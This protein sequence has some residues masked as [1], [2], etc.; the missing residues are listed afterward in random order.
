VSTLVG[1][2][3]FPPG[4]GFHYSSTNYLLLR[5]IAE[6]V[7]GE[8]VSAEI[9]RRFLAPLGLDHTV[10]LD[11]NPFVPGEYQV[12]HDWWDADGDG[13][14]DDVSSRPS[15]WIATRSPCVIYAT[16]A[17]L[18]RWSQALYGGEVLGPESRAEM[19]AFHRP[20]PTSPGEPLAT[21]YGLGTQELRLGGLEVWGHL[22]WQY[23]YTSAMLYLPKRSASIV[24]LL[25]DNN[26]MLSNLAFFSLWLVLACGQAVARCFAVAFS[27]LSLLST[28][29]LWPAN[30]LIRLIR[31]RKAGAPKRGRAEVVV[32]WVART[33]VVLAA[34]TLVAILCL[35]ILH[36][37]SPQ[38]PLVWRGGTPVVR[39]LLGL[40]AASVL[41]AVVLVIAGSLVWIRGYWTMGW[42][43]HYTLIVLGVLIGVYFSLQPV[44]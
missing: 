6:Q 9:R 23:G 7:T 40:S 36:S 41:L 32:T 44:L 34:V 11:S 24:V 4:E 27:A 16:A 2:P 8:P 13:V 42:R 25:N 39:L 22:G 31:K 20:A 21:G 30:G 3:Y 1:E 10:V 17:D 37:W 12:A 14:L 33:V 29:I 18:A 38:A 15:T 43:L 35:H 28:L 26:M 19:L 5:M